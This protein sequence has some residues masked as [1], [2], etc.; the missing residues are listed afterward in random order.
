MRTIISF[1]S[2]TLGL[3]ASD[4]A[5]HNIVFY[6]WRDKRRRIKAVRTKLISCALNA[7]SCH[8]PTTQIC[9]SLREEAAA[10][11]LCLCPCLVVSWGYD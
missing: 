2:S 6:T 10:E 11:V 7:R 8:Q 5:E 3:C 9:C 1:D 4:L